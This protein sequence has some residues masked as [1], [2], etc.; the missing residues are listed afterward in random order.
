MR[1]SA[2]IS[3]YRGDCSQEGVWGEGGTSS[4][5]GRSA[6]SLR[7][8]SRTSRKPG[9][10]QRESSTRSL[11]HSL[12]TTPQIASGS[13]RVQV[14]RLS[15]AVVCMQCGV[16]CFIIFN[17]AKGHLSRG[18]ISSSMNFSAISIKLIHL[19]IFNSSSFGTIRC[20]WWAW[21]N[22]LTLISYDII[23]FSLINYLRD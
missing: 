4:R 7:P 15:S 12:Y 14:P 8:R 21:H 17:S 19:F 9:W 2:R 13:L 3:S 1:C 6:G 22:Y 16:P 20:G 23:L 11:T 5:G 10:D 18:K